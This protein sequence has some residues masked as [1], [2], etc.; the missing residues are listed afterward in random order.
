M[1]S[2]FGGG[3]GEDKQFGLLVGLHNLQQPNNIYM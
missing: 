2:L 1:N 3:G